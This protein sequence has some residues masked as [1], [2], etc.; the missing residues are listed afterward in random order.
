MKTEVAMGTPA[1]VQPSTRAAFRSIKLLVRCYLGISVLTL[2]T[3]ILLR[4]NSS[5]VNAAVWIRGT[6]VVAAAVLMTT[7]AVRAARGSYR[8][9]LRLRIASAVMVAAI[10]VII[11][12]PDTFPLWMK[13]EQATCGTDPHRHRRRRQRQATPIVIQWVVDQT[14][15][16]R[17]PMT[18]CLCLRHPGAP[19]LGTSPPAGRRCREALGLDKG[20]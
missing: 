7:L 11:A 19:G 5:A 2:V 18:I 1:F 8:A 15:T 20:A 14:A 17:W 3:I 4:S 12:L 10:A 16:G 9:Y 13:I 6:I